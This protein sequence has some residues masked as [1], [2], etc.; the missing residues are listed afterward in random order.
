MGGQ[1]CPFAHPNVE[2]QS[3]QEL[4][5]FYNRKFT[6]WRYEPPEVTEDDKAWSRRYDTWSIGCII[7]EFLVWVV[8]GTKELDKFNRRIVNDFSQQC[9]YFE[10]EKRNG[11]TSFRVHTAVSAMMD[12]L[13]QR[14]ECTAGD[15]ALGDVLSV[16]RTRLLVVALDGGTFGKGKTHVTADS[17]VQTRAD[18]RT[19][20]KD[21]DEIIK[22]GDT[23]ELYWLQ[24]ETIDDLPSLTAPQDVQTEP[25]PQGSMIVTNQGSSESI[26]EFPTGSSSS[27]VVPILSGDVKVGF[28]SRPVS[29]TPHIAIDS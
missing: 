11:E 15:T 6:T 28:I 27:L 7:L 2:R 14:T 13:A 20:R 19:L 12:K 29:I 22:K 5:P 21:L 25:D 4:T 23:N 17:Q 9:H 10:V 3:G 24:G 8:Y 16:V 26:K 18:S 1:S